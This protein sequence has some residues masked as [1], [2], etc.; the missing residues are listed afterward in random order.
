MV[1]VPRLRGLLLVCLMLSP[2]TSAHA[3]DQTVTGTG[4]AGFS[5]VTNWSAGSRGYQ[6]T[7]QSHTW[8]DPANPLPGLQSFASAVYG[9]EWVMVAGR[10]NGMHD[11]TDSGEANFPPNRQNVDVYVVNPVTKQ[12]WR[13]SLADGTSLSLDQLSRLSATNT[14]SFQRGDGFFVAGGYGAILTSASYSSI[15]G[16][17]TI[18]SSGSF[19]THN[20]LTAIHLPELVGWVKSGTAA[21]PTSLPATAVT[22]ISG[23]NDF[24]AVTG[25]E[26]WRT[27]N[28][29]VHLVFGQN[30]QGPY[31]G[32]SNG[33][34]T[35]QVR[36]FTVDYTPGTEGGSSTLS[37]TPTSASPEPGNDTLFRR[38]DLNV[39]PSIRRDPNDPAAVQEGM[40]AYAGVFTGTAIATGTGT[41]SS[42]GNGVWTLPVEI[43]ATG[44]PTMVGTTSTASSF[45]QPMNQYASANLSVYSGSTGDFT[46]FMFGGI[47]A[48]T[49]DPQS[50]A[51]AY[52]AEYPFTNQITAVTRDLAGGYSQQYVG[53]YPFTPIVSGTRTF[54]LYGAE[55]KFFPSPGLPANAMFENGVFKID[56]LL[57]LGSGTIGYI[58]GGIVSSVPNTTSRFDSTAS[59]E[60][61]SVI[62]T[63]VP[64]PSAC[65]IAL[66]SL[67]CGGGLMWRRRKCGGRPRME[68]QR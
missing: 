59:P 30:F 17:T 58:F 18:V 45:V 37:Y 7:L 68:R 60:I 35:S 63:P 2:V 3:Q 19:V 36:S 61:F 33:I 12:T 5:P 34:Y 15:T 65:V 52:Q 39:V 48:N 53:E 8:S 32:A 56:E 64:E 49:Y 22:Q 55:A 43:S 25:G 11:F 38:R 67:A 54:S 51:L 21:A 50:G 4:S 29:Q 9:N 10:T 44:T 14:Q 16:S 1:S 27:A 62:I 66:A 24:F 20:S 40:I 13:R 46:T 57:A 26:T 23:S 28:D 31:T 41:I 6:I 47:T 42:A